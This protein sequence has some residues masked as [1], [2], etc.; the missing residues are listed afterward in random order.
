LIRSF[1]KISQD[2]SKYGIEFQ[3][4]P[5]STA[6][7]GAVRITKAEEYGLRLVMALAIDGG[8]LTIR[9]LGERESLP[10]TTVAKV[11][12]HLRR[13]G[14]VDA[15]RGRNGGY[16]LSEAPASLTLARVVEAFDEKM[17]DPGF[18]DRMSPSGGACAR[19]DSCGLRPVWRSLSDVIANYLAGIT[20]ADV[21]QQASPRPIA[22]APNGG[23]T[24]ATVTS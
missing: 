2:R 17:Y 11:I 15:E 24:P 14:I 10:E 5:L 9:E 8:Q 6:T 7:G 23:W 3:L 16:I 20:I 12:A 1:R 21:L 4:S 19:A 22:I 18:C 13:A